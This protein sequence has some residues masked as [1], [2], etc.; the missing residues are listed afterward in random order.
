MNGNFAL[1]GASHRTDEALAPVK[2]DPQ[3]QEEAWIAR[4]REGETQ[5]FCF[6][7][8]RYERMVRA[9]IRRLIA[10]EHDVDDLAQQ[11]FV[12][13]Y[14]KLA[15]FN[16]SCQFS[17]WL[18]QI[19]LNKARDAMRTRRYRQDDLDVYE[20]ELEG[21]DDGPQA[22]LEAQQEEQR[23]DR[24]L[25]VALGNLKPEERELIVLKYIQGY[26][27]DTVADMLGCT[28]QAAK[29]RSFRAREKL[30]EILQRFGV[31]L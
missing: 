1:G 4:C 23:L 19:A 14:E 31:E 8:E 20:L 13:A 12:S 26:G 17:T 28:V 7:V 11:S 6:L 5:A 10:T 29:V 24:Q 3:R 15:Q 27:Y 18:C 21:D 22:R 2:D 9:V 16:G 30:K 25:Q